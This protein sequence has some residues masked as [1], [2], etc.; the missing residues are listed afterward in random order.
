MVV[1]VLLVVAPVL[2]FVSVGLRHGVEPPSSRQPSPA[3]RACRHSRPPPRRTR[4]RRPR[5]APTRGPAVPADRGG[6]VAGVPHPAA[7]PPVTPW[8]AGGLGKGRPHRSRALRPPGV[9]RRSGSSGASRLRRRGSLGSPAYAKVPPAARGHPSCLPF[10]PMCAAGVPGAATGGH[11][12]SGVPTVYSRS[13]PA[14]TSPKRRGPGDG[15]PV[16]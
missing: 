1:V 3:D 7:F 2:V 4:S 16:E 6:A 13:G 10:V 15:D 14:P 11:R 8:R 5:S 9:P 12:D